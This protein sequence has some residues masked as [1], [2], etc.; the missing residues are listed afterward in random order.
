MTINED[1]KNNE[2]LYWGEADYIGY[3]TFEVTITPEGTL[4]D[5]LLISFTPAKGPS[6]SSDNE[7]KQYYNDW[8]K[9]KPKASLS[10]G[11]ALCAIS[12]FY[13]YK[14]NIDTLDTHQLKEMMIEVFLYSK[15]Q[16]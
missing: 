14:N 10:I 16:A 7:K 13:T 11:D 8:S 12:D 6:F 3:G 1:K 5:H 4:K 9:N 15:E 2:K